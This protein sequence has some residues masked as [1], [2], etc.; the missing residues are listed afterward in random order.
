MTFISATDKINNLVDTDK[1]R[2]WFHRHDADTDGH[3]AMSMSTKFINYAFDAEPMLYNSN[4][5]LVSIDRTVANINADDRINHTHEPN[6]F[7]LVAQTRDT[8]TIAYFSLIILQYRKCIKDR[9]VLIYDPRA[10]TSVIEQHSP[11]IKHLFD[12]LGDADLTHDSSMQINAR[13][14][15]ALTTYRYCNYFISRYLR[16]GEEFLTKVFRLNDDNK[17]DIEDDDVPLYRVKYRTTTMTRLPL[18]P[19]AQRVFVARQRS[20]IAH[21]LN[22]VAKGTV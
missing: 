8:N 22:G 6:V 5:G 7:I 4:I 1:M 14:K 20:S 18:P 10:H 11:L 21:R 19:V 12:Q 9:R 17:S 13:A 16:D 2:I 15:D 3:S